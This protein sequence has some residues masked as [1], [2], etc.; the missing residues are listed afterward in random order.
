MATTSISMNNDVEIS[1][2][3][4]LYQI[5]KDFDNPLQIFREGF[6]NAIDE[7]ATEVICHVY[8][9]DG[10]DKRDLVI[11]II[12]NGNGLLLEDIGCFFGLAKTTK[13]NSNKTRKNNK[14]G[15]KGHGS[16]IYFNADEVLIASRTSESSEWASTCINPIE[17]LIT[18]ESMKYSDAVSPSALGLNIPNNYEHGFMVRIINPKYFDTKSTLFMLNHDYLRDYIKWY[19]IFSTILTEFNDHK[20][21]NDLQSVLYLRGLNAD[22][23][24][25]EYNSI[26]KIDPIPMFVPVYPDCKDNG[27]YYKEIIK[28]GHYFPDERKTDTEMQ[29]YVSSIPECYKPFVHYFS[30]MPVCSTF[31]TDSGEKFRF[32]LSLEGYETKRRYDTLLS[33]RGKTGDVKTHTDSDRYG[34]WVCKGGVPIEKIDGWYAGKGTY[35]YIHAFVD[36]DDLDLVA[37]RSSIGNSNREL[38]DQIKKK[39]NEI[40]GSNEVV[41]ALK[42]RDAWEKYLDDQRYID[43]DTAELSKRFDSAKNKSKIIFQDGTEIFVPTKLKT[44]YSEAETMIVLNTIMIKYPNL[45]NFKIL[46][47]NTNKGIDYVIDINGRPGYIE[48]K[49]TLRET[50]NH[51]LSLIHKIICYDVELKKGTH[52]VDR[53]GLTGELKSFKDSEFRSPD[54]NFNKKLYTHHKLESN[55]NAVTSNI[56]VIVLKKLLKEILEAKIL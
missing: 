31:S 51:S 8:F 6:Q 12:D 29:K 39:L 23:F 35:T 11:D 45:F 5:I 46:D 9:R 54:L 49:G 53:E 21:L 2:W 25:K 18:S 56:E 41:K 4:E 55:S 38:L 34:I 27:G 44:G 22:D 24:A 40:M 30:S 52:I 50:M 47:Y 14:L 48:L 17:Q 15:Y 32:I 1:K 7:D 36:C 42:V 3:Y 26:E 43:D 19:T 33:K 16:K 28:L 20:W 13:L 37:N 10:L